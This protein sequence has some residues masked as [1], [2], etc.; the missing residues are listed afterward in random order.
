MKKIIGLGLILL[1]FPCLS[2][3]ADTIVFNDGMRVDA[4]GVREQNG[5]VQCEINGIVFGYPK[6]DVKRIE[7]NGSGGR[8]AETLTLEVHKEE[9]T[10][11]PKKQAAVPKKDK[12]ALKK[13]AV[14]PGKDA[15]SA[16]KQ[17]S[18]SKTEAVTPKKKAALPKAEASIDEPAKTL[19]RKS[20][21]PPRKEREIS[22][23]ATAT[24]S[25]EKKAQKAAAIEYGGIPS[26]KVIINEDD[27]NPPVYIKLQRVLLV[28]QGLKKAQ[29]RT[30]LL[31]YEKELRDELNAQKAGYKQIVIWAY[32]DFDRAKEGAAGWVGMISNEPVTGKLSDDPELLIPES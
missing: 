11:I 18:I 4:T 15:V 8:A 14:T 1:T 22:K 19:S 12:A 9:V 13:E 21:P 24:V 16:S 27:R 29:I 32:D 5:E 25:Q 31:S 28:S 10:V 17:A 7:K 2:A 6:A 20:A 26:F 30:L 3:F 23:K